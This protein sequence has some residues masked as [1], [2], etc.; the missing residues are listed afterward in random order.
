[1][2][3]LSFLY[4]LNVGSLS[5]GWLKKLVLVGGSGDSGNRG[6]FSFRSQSELR[7][8]AEQP[9][10]SFELKWPPWSATMTKLPEVQA[11]MGSDRRASEELR[12]SEK[13]MNSAIFS[14]RK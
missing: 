7:P 1:M 9:W 12:P 2:L 5:R 6:S 3:D 13:E 4:V 14:W 11:A 8:R 10:P